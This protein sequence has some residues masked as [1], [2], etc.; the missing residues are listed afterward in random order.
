MSKRQSQVA[1]RHT[2]V[3]LSAGLLAA[4]PVLAQDKLPFLNPDLPFTVDV[5]VTNTG[6]VAGDTV[7]QLYVKYAKSKVERPLQALAGFQR[8]NL[9]PGETRTVHIPLKSGQLAYWNVELGEDVR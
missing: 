8:I 1:I 3:A 4:T 6:N 5:D 2:M 7:V 9:A